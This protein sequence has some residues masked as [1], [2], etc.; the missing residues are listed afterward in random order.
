MVYMGSHTRERI[1]DVALKLFAQKGVAAT[2]ITAIE[3]CAGLAAGSGSFYCHFKDK[4][5]L[6]AAA[7]MAREKSCPYPEDP[8]GLGRTTA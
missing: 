1:M 6:L 8:R 2:A 5:E 7:Q 3:G 4:S